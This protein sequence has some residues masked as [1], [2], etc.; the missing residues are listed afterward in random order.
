MNAKDCIANPEGALGF[1]GEETGNFV[2]ASARAGVK[3]L[4][5]FPLYMY[6]PHH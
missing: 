3:N 6:I 2:R 4:S 5:T 1:N